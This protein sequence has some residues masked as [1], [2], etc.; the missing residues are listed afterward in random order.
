MDTSIGK[1]Q[2]RMARRGALTCLI[3]LFGIT[4]PV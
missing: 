1:Q 4:L 3:V 2:Q